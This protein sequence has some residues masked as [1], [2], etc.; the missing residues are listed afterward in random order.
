MR[1]SSAALARVVNE[2]L[3]EISALAKGTFRVFGQ[4]DDDAEAGWVYKH[5][6]LLGRVDRLP[7]RRSALTIHRGYAL[8]SGDVGSG[9]SMAIFGAAASPISSTKK[10]YFGTLFS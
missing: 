2:V 8:R 9:T 10:L 4:G 5:G 7:G 6:G 1:A 3:D